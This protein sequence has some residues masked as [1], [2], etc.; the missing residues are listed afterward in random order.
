MP[1]SLLKPLKTFN[2]SIK[3][4]LRPNDKYSFMVQLKSS[5]EILDV[6]CGNN[7]PFN[8]KRVLPGRTYT[9]IDIVDYNQVKP[10][11]ADHYVLT[12]PAEFLSAIGKF[13]D[14]FNTVI[15]LHD[16]ELCDVRDGTFVT[17]LDAIKPGGQPFI[18]FPRERSVH[19]PKRSGTLNDSTIAAIK[20]SPGYWTV[21][22]EQYNSG[23]LR[24]K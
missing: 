3:R 1:K 2:E 17:M 18:S 8:I 19:F 14:C 20:T 11:L 9:G 5:A 6:G 21:S 15:S 13:R 23:N 4:A 7:S 16:F 12:T 24:H 22:C 10:N